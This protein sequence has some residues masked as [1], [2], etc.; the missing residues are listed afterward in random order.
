MGRR[1][2]SY[3]C[4]HARQIDDMRTIQFE[5][6]D[7][8]ASHR[9]QSDQFGEIVAPGEMLVPAVAARMEQR[10]FEQSHRVNASGLDVFDVVAT[11]AGER[12]IALV[13]LAACFF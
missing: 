2:F 13:A 5:F 8:C 6:G 1:M 11:D 7:G 9:C 4:Q 3:C 12:E 10:C